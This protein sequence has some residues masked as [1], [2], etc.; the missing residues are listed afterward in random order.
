MLRRTHLVALLVLVALVLPTAP[1]SAKL[2]SKR[3]WEQDVAGAMSGSH[4]YVDQR[5]QRGG[6]RLAVNFDIDNTTLAS[7]YDPGKPV[8]R[9]LRFANYAR[10]QGVSLL[11][12][13][14]RLRGDGRVKKAK[15]QLSRAGY[16]VDGICLRRKG[17]GLT[18]S[19]IR[20]RTSF[21]SQGYTLIANVG[22]RA[23]DFEGGYYDKAY[24]LPNY[25]NQLT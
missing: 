22:N 18:H 2:P 13:T 17:E 8:K 3:A 12:N 15:R 5:V 25:N 9:V 14:A 4:Y 20:C 16:V 24:R 21:V 6:R 23:T 7:H 19:K 10:S 11:F 1:A